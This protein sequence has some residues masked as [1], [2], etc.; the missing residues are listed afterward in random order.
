MIEYRLH[1]CKTKGM[2]VIIKIV[3][4]VSHRLVQNQSINQVARKCFNPKL[5]NMSFFAY[6]NLVVLV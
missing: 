6:S 1:P 4:S 5:G 2:V 3:A